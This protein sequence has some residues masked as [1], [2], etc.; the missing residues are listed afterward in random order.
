MTPAPAKT[1]AVWD[2]PVRLV[3][4]GVAV[5]VPAMWW[6][7]ENGEMRWHMRLGLVL[8]ALLLFRIVWGFVGTRTARFGTFLSSPTSAVRYLLGRNDPPWQGLGHNPAGAWS[9]VGLL[10]VMSLQ[11]TTGLFAGDP[12]DGATGPLN[13]LVGV[14]RADQL[15]DWHEWLFDGLVVLIG[16]H[17]AAIAFYSFVRRERL[18]GPM[19]SG[20]A[21][22][23]ESASAEGNEPARAWSV[24]LAA[25]VAL[26]VVGWIVW[27]AGSF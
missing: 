16:L 13:H 2:L 15:T 1:L 17:L 18:V 24:V 8:L 4:W 11:V 22:V 3:H 7:A 12:Y 27:E 21:E 9:V 14:L 25:A 10:S 20:K 5:I 19:L 26:S 23:D 6:T